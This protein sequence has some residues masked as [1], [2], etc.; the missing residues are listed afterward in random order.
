[1]FK[2]IG[3]VIVVIVIADAI[4]NGAFIAKSIWSGIKSLVNKIKQGK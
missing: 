4:F 1:M 3:I 2:L